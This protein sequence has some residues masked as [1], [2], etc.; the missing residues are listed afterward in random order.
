[1]PSVLLL[2]TFGWPLCIKLPVLPRPSYSINPCM[3]RTCVGST[4]DRLSPFGLLGSGF[5]PSWAPN[6]N[7]KSF[8]CPFS[9]PQASRF[10]FG[11]FLEVLFRAFAV[12]LGNPIGFWS[13]FW[14]HFALHGSILV[15]L[16]SPRLHFS[17][18]FDHWSGLLLLLRL[19]KFIS[20]PCVKR[21]IR[22]WRGEWSSSLSLISLLFS[23]K[24]I[25]NKKTVK[26]K[27]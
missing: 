8:S 17:S 9:F 7:C 5:G 23:V 11:A 27:K 12:I 3:K 2:V 18:L 15:A 20:N 1:M 21:M 22:T 25:K 10:V 19:L 4:L 24:T 14:L 6:V 13:I 16:V 26:T